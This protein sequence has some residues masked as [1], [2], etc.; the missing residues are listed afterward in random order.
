MN[1][2]WRN[3]TTMDRLHMGLHPVS[4][5][6]G[7]NMGKCSLIQGCFLDIDFIVFLFFSKIKHS[8]NTLF[9]ALLDF[10]D[11]KT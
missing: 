2:E 3:D 9:S 6:S 5:L 10:L 4:T 11:S 1:K 8:V 7:F